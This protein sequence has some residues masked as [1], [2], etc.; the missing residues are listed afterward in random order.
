MYMY[1]NVHLSLYPSTYVS[2]CST[3]V[4]MHNEDTFTASPR[5]QPRV[6]TPP[7]KAGHY[8]SFVQLVSPKHKCIYVIIYIYLVSKHIHLRLALCNHFIL[9]WWLFFIT[10]KEWL[11]P[12]G[13]K[14]VWWPAL[15]WEPLEKELRQL[16][17]G[18]HGSPFQRPCCVHVW[19][20][21]RIACVHKR[22][23]IQW[24]PIFADTWKIDMQGISE[25]TSKSKCCQLYSHSVP[26]EVVILT[27][28]HQYSM[29]NTVKL[30]YISHLWKWNVELVPHQTSKTARGHIFRIPGHSTPIYHWYLKNTEVH[31][32]DLRPSTGLTKFVCLRTTFGFVVGPIRGEP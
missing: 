25:I 24:Y 23:F 9:R 20:G 27:D 6:R 16:A 28:I 30:S 7:P 14:W 8:T 32:L 15:S 5:R 19:V 18:G 2:V 29:K 10:S 21:S 31:C 13:P 4:D 26:F 12:R 1:V 22:T 17:R 3:T 11:Q